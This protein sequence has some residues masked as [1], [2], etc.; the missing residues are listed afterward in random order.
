MTSH[1]IEVSS[2]RCISAKLSPERS[3]VRREAAGTG[4]PFELVQM[5]RTQNASEAKSSGDDR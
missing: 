1:E 2:I 5:E 3:E 4:H